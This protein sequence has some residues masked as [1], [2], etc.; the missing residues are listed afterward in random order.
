[1]QDHCNPREFGPSIFRSSALVTLS[2]NL[3]DAAQLMLQ[4]PLAAI[5]RETDGQ[6]VEK[7]GFGK[8][9]VTRLFRSPAGWHRDGF[10][11]TVRLQC[12]GVHA[13]W[14]TATAAKRRRANSSE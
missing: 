13:Y 5:E 2:P 8:D 11:A 10:S 1:M 7:D 14:A 6:T 12:I 3:E 4:Q 9:F